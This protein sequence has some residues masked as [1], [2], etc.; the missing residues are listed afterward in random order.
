MNLSYKKKKQ[1]LITVTLCFVMMSAFLVSRNQIQANA[2]AQ[3][4]NA[5]YR[6][7]QEIR[8]YAAANSAGIR[9]NFTFITDPYTEVPYNLGR[10]TDAT[11]Q[12]ALNMLNQ[13]RY[14]AGISDNVT[15]STQY[16]EYAQAAA[17][18]NYINGQ[19]SHNPDQPYSMGN[20][21]FQMAQR[22][23]AGS[24][25]AWATWGNRSLNETILNSW[26]GN[27]D[28]VDIS[29]LEERRWLL[30]PRLRQTGFGVVSGLKGTFSSV[31]VNDMTNTTAYE[32]GVAW[33]ARTMPVEYF[34]AEYPWSYSLGYAVNANDLEV[35]LL[36]YRDYKTW[37]FTYN[38]VS[39]GEF[40]V[41]N[42]AYGQPGCIIFRPSG[43]GE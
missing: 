25:N 23:A 34:A 3:G 41:N 4:I 28:S 21:M 43:I 24:N 16:A 22:G 31:Y 35:T 2:T 17:L 20:T 27:A 30:N 15:I 10:L 14:I 26:M 18:V 39:D 8:S 6:T 33:P 11:Q 12:S 13:I 40:F 19:V 29:A 32:T 7:A 36:R 42:N 37:R 9:D 5:R 38:G 1:L